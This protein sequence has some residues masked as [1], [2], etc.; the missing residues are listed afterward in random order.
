MLIAA[1]ITSASCWQAGLLG[2]M[3]AAWTW[4]FLTSHERK[5]FGKPI[6]E[7]QLSAG[8]ARRHVHDAGR[9]PRLCLFGFARLSDEAA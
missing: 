2:I 7:F 4:S 5:Q 8:Q 6:G 1:S 9:E 3:Q